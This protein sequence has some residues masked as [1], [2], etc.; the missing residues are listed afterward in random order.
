MNLR[1]KDPKV[2]PTLLHLI[3]TAAMFCALAWA[4]L[5]DRFGLAVLFGVAVVVSH[6]TDSHDTLL[7]EI[8]GEN[9]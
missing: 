8:R 4:V 5:G 3:V 6:I 2:W 9:R 1:A 7:G